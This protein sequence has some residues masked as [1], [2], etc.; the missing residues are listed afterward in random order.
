[1]MFSPSGEP[2]NDGVGCYAIDCTSQSSGTLH[3]YDQSCT[4]I[5][6]SVAVVLPLNTSLYPQF[7]TDSLRYS[8]FSC[9]DLSMYGRECYDM[10]AVNQ[11]RCTC[12]YQQ[13][14]DTNEA[15]SSAGWYEASPGC[16]KG[17]S[18]PPTAALT[19]H[20]LSLVVLQVW[21]M[22]CASAASRQ[23]CR[24]TRL[25]LSLQSSNCRWFGSVSLGLQR[26]ET[27]VV[28]SF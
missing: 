24:H 7:F 22:Q 21:N 16:H 28:T 5:Q 18:C 19:P 8:E 23:A 6:S 17:G 13:C 26:R 9:V 10:E 27:V 15:D 20:R 14:K 3:L 25:Y 4:V 1:M 11:T 2:F 12:S